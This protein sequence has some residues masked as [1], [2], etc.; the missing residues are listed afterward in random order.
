LLELQQEEQ[1]MSE[2]HIAA[3]AR[4]EGEKRKMTKIP[5]KIRET[6]FNQEQ[7]LTIRTLAPLKSS[8]KPLF[9]RTFKA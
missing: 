6:R 5:A 7:S 1:K 2:P 9:H 4:F 3:E 8:A